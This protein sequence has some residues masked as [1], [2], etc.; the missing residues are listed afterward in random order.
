MRNLEHLLEFVWKIWKKVKNVGSYCCGS[1]FN[2]SNPE[3]K[4]HATARA[5]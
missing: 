2:L 1:Q 5:E 4:S 3:C